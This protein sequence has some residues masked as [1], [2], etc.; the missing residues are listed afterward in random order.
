M[1]FE[2]IWNLDV[3][4]VEEQYQPQYENF[5]ALTPLVLDKNKT[6]YTRAL[7]SAFMNDDIRNIAIMGI[8][9][10]GKSTLWKTYVKEKKLQNIITISLGK[11]EDKN[12]FDDVSDFKNQS[13]QKKDSQ[14]IENINRIERQLINQILSQ[15]K[16]E[17]IPLNKYKFKSNKK[18]KD[19]VC[20]TIGLFCF[21]ISI[22]LWLIKDTLVYNFIT[23]GINMKN[24]III[25]GFLF[26]IPLIY[27]LYLLCKQ[28]RFRISKI[29]IKGTEADLCEE[30]NKDETVLDRD[31]KEIVYLITS[32]DSEVIV[33]EDLDR[34]DDIT[35]FTKLRELNFIL[36]KY[37]MTNIHNKPI[38]FIYMLR[39]GLFY[40]KN[41]TKFFDFIIPVVP[42][43]DSKTSE[44][45]LHKLLDGVNYLPND[46][47]IGNISLY[48]D[49]MRLLKNIVNEYIIYS[50]ILPM[51][52]LK[53]NP[54]K[55]FSLLTVKNIFPNEFDLLQEDRGFIHSIFNKLEEYRQNEIT[56]IVEK[57]NGIHFQIEK[58]D[59]K[60]EDKVIEK[61]ASLITNDVH[62]QYG[63]KTWLNFL[64]EWNK[65]KKDKH[66]IGY[67]DYSY[68]NKNYNYDEFIEKFIST[69]KEYHD[70][71]ESL[72]KIKEDDIASLEE[73]IKRLNTKKNQI[74]IFSFKE[75]IAC[76]TTD[77]KENLF[78]DSSD[79]KYTITRE[80]YFP[81]V[82]YLISDGLIDETYWYYKGNC[83]V[84]SAKNDKIYCK[85]LLE[86]KNLDIFLDI[87]NPDKII[88][89]LEDSDFNRF[90]I[91]NKNLLEECI[92]QDFEQKAIAIT[93]SALNNE[94]IEDLIKIF[95]VFPLNILSNYINILYNNNIEN[96]LFITNLCKKDN[97]DLYLNI[98]VSVVSKDR[99][100]SENFI[101]FKPY[102]EG[103]ETIIS[104]I[105][106]ESF[107]TFMENI[108]F[109][110][111]K[112]NDLTRTNIDL[113]RL[114]KLEKS[115]AYKLNLTNLQYIINKMLGKKAT[116][117]KLLDIIF[118]SDVLKSTKVYLENN[119]LYF[120]KKYIDAVPSDCYFDNKEI[121]TLYIFNSEISDEYKLKYA[122]K[123]TT[124][125]SDITKIK[126]IMEKDDLLKC[127]FEKNKSKFNNDNIDFY[128]NN[129][130]ETYFNEF[131]DFFE[132][133]TSDENI[134]DILQNNKTISNA[135]IENN[136]VSDDLFALALKNADTKI[137]IIDTK[138]PQQRINLLIKNNLIAPTKD[139]I[140]TLINNKY[141]DEILLL[142]TSEEQEVQDETIVEILENEFE[143]DFI[144]LLLNST[145]NYEN[146]TKIIDAYKDNILI[147]R[148]SEKK[149]DIIKYIIDKYLSE[150]NIDYICKNFE[151]FKLKKDFIN[152]LIH[153]DCI[154]EL[155]YN[156]LNDNVMLY[157]LEHKDFEIELKID[158]ILIKIKNKCEDSYLRKYISMV[159]EIRD[160][161]DV[162]N[163]KHPS[164]NDNEFKEKIAL[165][166]IKY[167][168][169]VKTSYKET[170]KIYI[171]KKYND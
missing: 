4:E 135:F 18:W 93:K 31:I 5:N 96:L 99:R 38:R 42:I 13:N 151:I 28:N 160:L 52:K 25:I 48:I 78:L 47:T 119:F 82:R 129:R 116:Y 128:W 24:I 158:L 130:G 86:G 76:M 124:I 92:K 169:V 123:N 63:D 154:N 112:F 46:K 139:N 21:I 89:K 32:S 49:D 35:I 60:I 66:I 88:E 74:E 117:S 103:T 41:R 37:C 114:K 43:V 36:N 72:P 127:L 153:K 64:K 10:A 155:K 90:N 104:T 22:I 110:D 167:G 44:E 12:D 111:I 77:E 157:I 51:E 148:I 9:G 15:I 108:R 57:I 109:A 143:D 133:N 146:A 137:N 17:L 16:T 138:L 156:Q 19:I 150:E 39:D 87:E 53:L 163:N 102:I 26:C 134:E 136:N 8:Y 101:E 141:F 65:N 33:F 58:L 132:Q 40:S 29:N 161:A 125:L 170:P 83:D 11:Y 30:T 45:I 14:N 168:Y 50:N 105:S 2:N 62:V 69:K 115:T 94:K 68:T 165:S 70:L 147:E 73:K 75:L 59:K 91:L 97:F 126:N 162:W 56:N 118:E 80:H 113:E 171:P 54:N 85:G 79:N 23:I 84:Y 144:Y 81:L 121:I 95:N 159:D 145:I 100:D 6:I 55:L 131:V 71:I 107:D 166:L 142:A 3:K 122:E 120:I 20:H 27:F 106:N 34:Y 67:Y 164:Y 149:E 152:S 98:L 1:D 61:I 140:N 7:N